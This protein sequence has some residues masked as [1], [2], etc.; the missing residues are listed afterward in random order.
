MKPQIQ[1]NPSVALEV[2]SCSAHMP[3]QAYYIQLT[4]SDQLLSCYNLSSVGCVS[5]EVATFLRTT[6][7]YFSY[8]Y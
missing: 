3:C 5:T 4:T 7:S 1:V 8:P 2:A 6:N